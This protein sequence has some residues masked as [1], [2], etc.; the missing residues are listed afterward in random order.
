VNY[1]WAA[2][3]ERARREADAP[4][5][6]WTR[7]RIGGRRGRD[8]WR[9]GD[10]PY[11]SIEEPPEHEGDP[12]TAAARRRHLDREHPDRAGGWELWYS[13][14]T[15]WLCL[16]FHPT[17]ALAKAAAQVLVNDADGMAELNGRR[18]AAGS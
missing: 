8:I 10:P 5:L 16:S 9:A 17:L 4:A 3:A 18:A 12:M 2:R 15:T 13:T 14:P 7:Q 11:W 1:G 6:E